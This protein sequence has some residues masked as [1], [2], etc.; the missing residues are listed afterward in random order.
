MEEKVVLYLE[1][2]MSQMIQDW[3]AK[4]SGKISIYGNVRW[5]I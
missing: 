2:K 1:Y 3:K 4:K 5:Y